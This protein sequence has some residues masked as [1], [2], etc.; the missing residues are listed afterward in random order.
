MDDHRRVGDPPSYEAYGMSISKRMVPDTKL[1]VEDW[2]MAESF[3]E[4]RETWPFFRKLREALRIDRAF[5]K[6]R[7]WLTSPQDL[8]YRKYIFF[9]ALIAVKAFRRQ[10]KRGEVT[11]DAVIQRKT[12]VYRSYAQA[13]NEVEIWTGQSC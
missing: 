7:H 1:M 6:S 9:K 3:W 10:V 12:A 5:I 11:P 2:I 8:Q 4:T 13:M